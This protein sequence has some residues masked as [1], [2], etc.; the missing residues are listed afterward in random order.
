MYVWVYIVY[1]IM[2]RVGG[3]VGRGGVTSWPALRGTAGTRVHARSG[4]NRAACDVTGIVLTSP[5]RLYTTQLILGSQMG[6][7]GV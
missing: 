2:P 5:A 7:E 1:C 4:H 3:G 6:G